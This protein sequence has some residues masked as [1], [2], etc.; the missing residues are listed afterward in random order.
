[1]SSA[2][3]QK[4]LSIVLVSQMITAPVLA[5][6]LDY[7]ELAMTPRYFERLNMEA[8]D[9]DGSAWLQHLPIQLG[10][11]TNVAGSI[12]MLADS[13]NQRERAYPLWAIPMAVGGAWLGLT[14]GLAAA[15]RP[16]TKGVEKVSA[17]PSKTKR[18]EL[19]RER[20]AE[21]EIE[22]ANSLAWRLT[23]LSV[24]TQ[25]ISGGALMALNQ[26][27][28]AFFAGV[29]AAVLSFAPLVFQY[30]WSR[31]ACEQRDYKKRIYAPIASAGFVPEVSQE[32]NF[33]LAP[34][35]NLSFSF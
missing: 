14:I 17:M 24:T 31:V 35:M 33:S 20:M 9:E 30:R 29:G 26:P 11:V 1:M 10:A 19:T 6:E 21:Q 4:T 13:T 15:Y 8:K 12:M 32:G 5:A 18:E 7:P 27:G 23:I 2:S 34:T 28:P 25:A 22:F 16:Y 3:F